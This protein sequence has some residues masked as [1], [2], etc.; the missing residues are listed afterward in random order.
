MIGVGALPGK[1]DIA[2]QEND[3]MRAQSILFKMGRGVANRMPQ[4]LLE[5]ETG[6]GESGKQRKALKI[7]D[8]NTF[9]CNIYSSRMCGV[10]GVADEE[11][12]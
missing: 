12:M 7:I 3:G 4:A 5:R 10:E 9:F 8:F 6:G 2:N 1:S 11:G